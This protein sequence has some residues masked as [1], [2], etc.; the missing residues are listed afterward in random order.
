M[1]ALNESE[2]I[3]AWHI[4][5]S[6]RCA[7]D[8]ELP[9]I[10]SLQVEGHNLTLHATDNVGIARVEWY[11]NNVLHTSLPVSSPSVVTSLNLSTLGLPP[12]QTVVVMCRVYDFEGIQTGDRPRQKRYVE[13]KERVKIPNV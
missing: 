2:R 4:F 10:Q 11:V 13:R 12:G 7:Y 6:R 1:D 5:E 8:M 9:F 3:T